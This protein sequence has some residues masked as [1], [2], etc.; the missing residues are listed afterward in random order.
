MSSF[1]SRFSYYNYII[2]KR[3][4][5]AEQRATEYSGYVSCEND[6][7]KLVRSNRI[8]TNVCMCLCVD[9]FRRSKGNFALGRRWGEWIF[10]VSV[11]HETYM[12][13]R[14]CFERIYRCAVHA[15]SNVKSG[16]TMNTI[17][18]ILEIDFDRKMW[19]LLH[20]IS[21][22]TVCDFRSVE[23]NE[24]LYIESVT[25]TNKIDIEWHLGN[26]LNTLIK[27]RIK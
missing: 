13:N 26:E 7:G 4:T 15:Y 14:K 12:G 17:I 22:N 20:F 27:H 16:K 19:K 25:T 21:K 10:Y 2:E 11:V 8:K 5:Y 9:T 24:L 6:W 1:H 18:F 3:K 23:G